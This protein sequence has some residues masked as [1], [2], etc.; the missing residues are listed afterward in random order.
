M[1]TQGS[2]SN[3][4]KGVRG[5]E[6]S[7]PISQRDTKITTMKSLVTK[8]D[9]DPVTNSSS[10]K[11]DFTNKLNFMMIIPTIELVF[12]NICFITYLLI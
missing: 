1:D 4:K 12:N 6:L 7:L 8:A 9:P 10:T 2:Q 3:P 11:D 5:T